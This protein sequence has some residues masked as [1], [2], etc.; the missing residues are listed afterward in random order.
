MPIDSGDHKTLAP[1]PGESEV[2]ANAARRYLA[3]ATIDALCDD[4]NSR[5]I[6]SPTFKGQPGKHWHAKT[7]AGL[8]RNPAIAGRRM[9]AKGKTILTYEGIIT[10][11]DHQRLV[12]RLDSRAH[13]KGISPANVALL[14]ST[15]FDASGHPMYRINGWQGPMYYCR[16]CHASITVEEADDMA[17]EAVMEYADEP[18]MVQR[19]I[20]GKNHD[21]EIARL[22]Q[23]RAELDDLADDYDERHAALTAD[24]RRLTKL[25]KDDPQP[26]EV[27]PVRSGRT[28]GQVWE[29]LDTAGRRDWLRENGWTFTVGENGVFQIDEGWTAGI[30]IEEQM[31]SFA[32]R[33]T[34]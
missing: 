10:W 34:L 1:K 21:D 3:G 16:K 5:G 20:P 29:S 26:N 23:D 27:K 15:I 11:E 32:T 18:H 8:L 19:L 24:I 31:E 13:R 6:P 12:A 22:R 14:T 2:I 7:L 17:N 30:G 25:D 4:L 28:I 33:E 9:D